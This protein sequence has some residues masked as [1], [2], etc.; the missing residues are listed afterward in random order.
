MNQLS[1]RGACMGNRV[2]QQFGNYRLTQ[3]LGRGGFAE[4][5]LGLHLH[6]ET[7]AAIKV[8]H[9]PLSEEDVERFRTEARTVARLEHPH[10][11]RLL[12]FGVEETTAFLVMSY[13][14]HGSLRQR[15][16]KGR[17]VALS[18]IVHYVKQIA[19]ALQYAHDAQ[20]IHRDLKPENLLLGR[21]HE[22][23]LSDFG[24][25]LALPHSGSLTTKEMAGTVPYTAPEQLLGK[26][27]QA[28]DQY[29]LGI[30]VYEWLCGVRP[31]EGSA[32][33]II[34]Q[35]LRA[36]PPPLRANIPTLA[37]AVEEVVLRTL[38]KDPGQRFATVQAFATALEQASLA[39]T[40]AGARWSGGLPSKDHLA[41]DERSRPLSEQHEP[42][43]K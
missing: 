16:P 31:F 3:F 43:P 19:A 36:L 32:L 14:P 2:G 40:Q 25:V 21:N 1:S 34:T 15:Y 42:L 24:L 12:E 20:L 41:L 10:I 37:P 38:A 18:S 29:S 27:R 6:L 23:L 35:H 26:P 5:Y 30:I 39:D 28:S 4:I 9:T 33:E 7:Q 8:Q 13:A 11:V 17:R 22:V